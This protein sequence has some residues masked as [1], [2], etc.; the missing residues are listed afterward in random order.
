MIEI[1]QECVSFQTTCQRLADQIRTII[2]KGWF[3]DLGILE[4]HQ[5]M[6]NEQD[7]NIVLDTPSKNKQKQSNLNELPTLENRN[8]TQPNNTEKILTQEQKVNLKN[9]KRIM[10][11]EKTISPSLRNID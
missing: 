3:S 2:K 9:L 5:K 1:W 8:A 4:T 11:W 6:N 10:N 7:S